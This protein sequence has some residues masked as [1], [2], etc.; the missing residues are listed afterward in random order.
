[1]TEAQSKRTALAAKLK[2]LGAR[3]SER[4]VG[5]L[6]ALDHCF[7]RLHAGAPGA[8]SEIESIAHR[9]SGT[10]ATL[11]FHVISTA[12]E[13]LERMAES[14]D[15]DLTRLTDALAELRSAIARD[16]QQV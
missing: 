12:A 6:A 7:E 9:M 2:E 15:A 16:E 11:G 8:L 1:V 13:A 5:D 3:F 4:N 10:G 14:K